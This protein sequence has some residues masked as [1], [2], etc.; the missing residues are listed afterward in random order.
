MIRAV[1]VTNLQEMS[2]RL[3]ALVFILLLPLAF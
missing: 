1:F 3:T 2:R